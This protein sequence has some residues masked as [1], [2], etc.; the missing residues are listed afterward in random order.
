MVGQISVFVHNKAVT[1]MVYWGQGT[2]IRDNVIP[3][4]GVALRTV[5]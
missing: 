2:H 1:V 4:M 3:D 5:V